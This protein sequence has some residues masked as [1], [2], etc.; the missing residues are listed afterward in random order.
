MVGDEQNRSSLLTK[1]FFSFGIS[2]PVWFEVAG[3]LDGYGF[4]ELE[5][6]VWFCRFQHVSVAVRQDCELVALI[7]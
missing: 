5:P 4:V 1:D 6:D 3:L 7:A 2:F